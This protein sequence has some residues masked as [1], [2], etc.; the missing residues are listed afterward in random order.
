[1]PGLDLQKN[2]AL[3]MELAAALI[4]DPPTALTV[5]EIRD[6]AGMVTLSGQVG[7]REVRKRLEQITSQHP[8]VLCTI[9]DL[10]VPASQTSAQERATFDG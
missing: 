9:N 2:T 10:D 4:A 3:L 5:V 6:K 1:M 8:G 7:S